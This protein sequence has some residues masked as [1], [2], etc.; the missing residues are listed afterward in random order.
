MRAKYQTAKLVLG[1][2]FLCAGLMGCASANVP[3]RNV[4]ETTSIISAG[5][6]GIP[7]VAAIGLAATALELLTKT[8][9]RPSSGVKALFEPYAKGKKVVAFM[10]FISA[11]KDRFGQGDWGETEEIKLKN[12]SDFDIGKRI[13]VLYSSQDT[14]GFELVYVYDKDATYI[15]VMTPKEWQLFSAN[16]VK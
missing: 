8:E 7:G 2:S 11:T 6:A 13:G 5:G 15:S 4:R 9:H 14:N 1:G 16:Q 3:A 10:K 12:Y